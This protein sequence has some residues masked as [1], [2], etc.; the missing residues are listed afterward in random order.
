MPIIDP[1]AARPKHRAVLAHWSALRQQRGAIPRRRDLDACAF[2]A[3]LGDV[4]L[5]KVLQSGADYRYDLVGEHIRDLFGV[6]YRRR[7]LREIGFPNHERLLQEYQAVVRGGEPLYLERQQISERQLN[8]T[9]GKL[10]LPLSDDGKDVTD[11]L[12]C[13]ATIG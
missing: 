10:I 7:T 8:V 2:I 6:A 5:L 9:I 3:C 4:M 13:L 12:V 11:L 1:Q